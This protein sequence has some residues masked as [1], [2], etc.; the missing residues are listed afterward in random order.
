MPKGIF[1]LSAS[2]GVLGAPLNKFVP[3]GPGKNRVSEPGN[4]ILPTTKLA[5]SE[6]F[7]NSQGQN[8][9]EATGELLKSLSLYYLG[10]V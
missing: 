1:N 9:A 6:P 7:G 3:R 2:T 5:G 10:Y 8:G 4:S